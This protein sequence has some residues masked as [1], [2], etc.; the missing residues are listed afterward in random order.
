M[1]EQLRN[2]VF[3]RIFWFLFDQN[4]ANS[5]QNRFDEGSCRKK[6]K[7]TSD[8]GCK[9]ENRARNYSKKLRFVSWNSR[10]RKMTRW[11][12][13]DTRPLSAKAKGNNDLSQYRSGK[14]VKQKVTVG[15]WDVF[16][17]HLDVQVKIEA[18]RERE[19]KGSANMG[20]RFPRDGGQVRCLMD[21]DGHVGEISRRRSDERLEGDC[22]MSKWRARWL[23]KVGLPGRD[24]I[25]RNMHRKSTWV[26]TFV[27]DQFASPGLGG[28]AGQDNLLTRDITDKISPIREDLSQ[29]LCK[30]E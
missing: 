30:T 3:I 9:F 5:R 10:S 23:T 8:W 15:R 27:S 19:Q 24:S 25:G 21:S 17:A 12:K 13:V 14:N 16:S 28:W 18:A 2:L 20:E 6:T 22:R 11:K 7:F 29:G 1:F 26:N 4:L